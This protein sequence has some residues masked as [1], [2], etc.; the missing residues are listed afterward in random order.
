LNFFIF[1]PFFTLYY[2]FYVCKDQSPERDQKWRMNADQWTIF[3]A[4]LI[5]VRGTIHNGPVRRQPFGKHQF[6]PAPHFSTP[7][8]LSFPE[9]NPGQAH[10]IMDPGGYRLT[11][12]KTNT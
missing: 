12:Q 9:T 7:D 11:N 4:W 3:P 8:L 10:T 5:P 2:F 1:S 6:F